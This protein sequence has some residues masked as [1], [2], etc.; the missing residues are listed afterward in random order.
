VVLDD[1]VR[2]LALKARRVSTRVF[3]CG[4]I[5]GLIAELEQQTDRLEDG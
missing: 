2:D 5:A 4:G 3:A 1:G